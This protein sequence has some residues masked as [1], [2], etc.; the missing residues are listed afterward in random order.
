MAL[1]R[2]DEVM[3]VWEEFFADCDVLIMPA[4]TGTAEQHG[5][6]PTEPSQEY[7]HSLSMVSGCPMIVIL[8]RVDSQGLPC[9]L[10]ILARRWDDERLLDIA[11]SFVTANGWLPTIAGLLRQEVDDGH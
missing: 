10:Q 9:G 11:E 7:P 2:R 1:D 6:E 8:A 3:R 5:E 4:G